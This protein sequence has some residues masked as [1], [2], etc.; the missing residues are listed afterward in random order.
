[1]I[2]HVVYFFE[3]IDVDHQERKRR[4]ISIGQRELAREH[5]VERAFVRK[6]RE[7]VGRREICELGV[8]ALQLA[9]QLIFFGHQSG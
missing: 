9:G 5:V 3:V 4:R 8:C 2:S 7:A 1:M 6:L